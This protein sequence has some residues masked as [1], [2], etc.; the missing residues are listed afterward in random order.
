MV[1]N[2]RVLLFKVG[3]DVVSNGVKIDDRCLPAKY[4]C[5][6]PSRCCCEILRQ[7]TGETLKLAVLS[8]TLKP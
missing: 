5:H 4:K 7:D 1:V 3:K 2:N 8:G 6:H